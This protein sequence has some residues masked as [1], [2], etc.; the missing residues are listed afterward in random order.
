MPGARGRTEPPAPLAADVRILTLPARTTSPQNYRVCG[1]IERQGN[2]NTRQPLREGA[3]LLEMLAAELGVNQSAVI[4]IAIR[5]L[6]K[7]ERNH[8]PQQE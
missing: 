2:G 7:R 5:D 1:C 8:A 4:E 3:D 6:A